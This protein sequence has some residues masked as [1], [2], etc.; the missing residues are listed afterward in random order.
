MLFVFLKSKFV[1]VDLW[2]TN[3]AMQKKSFIAAL[4]PSP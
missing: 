1:I 4:S 3:K 2:L